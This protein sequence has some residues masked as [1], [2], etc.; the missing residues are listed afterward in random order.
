MCNWATP[1]NLQSR[2]GGQTAMGRTPQHLD[3]GILQ[4]DSI[5]RQP[6]FV[7]HVTEFEVVV[8]WVC[9]K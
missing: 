3:F 4:V 2:G 6:G 5:L 9:R 7:Q 1:T 8:I